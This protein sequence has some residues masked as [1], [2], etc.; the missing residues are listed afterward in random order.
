MSQR[1]QQA[2]ELALNVHGK[3]TRKGSEIPYISHVMAVSALVMELGGD[4]DTA[5]VALL[6]DSIED[7]EGVVTHS[8]LKEKFG[9][10]VADKVLCLSDATTFPKPTWKKRKLAY[11]ENISKADDQTLLVCACDKWHNLTSLLRDLD[12]SGDEVWD[13]FSAPAEEQFWYYQQVFN[14]VSE[15]VPLWLAE[16]L[17]EGLEE[18]ETMLFDE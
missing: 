11:V 15:R 1:F 7:S 13:R 14:V 9:N 4:E 5:I 16:R 17:E 3:Q 12:D 8:I 6:H 18:L 10:Q 2:L